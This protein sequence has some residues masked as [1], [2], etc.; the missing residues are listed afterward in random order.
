LIISCHQVDL[1]EDGTIEMLV[2]IVMDTMNEVAAGADL[3]T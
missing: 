1:A 3:G 2:G